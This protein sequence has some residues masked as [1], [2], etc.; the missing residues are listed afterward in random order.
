MKLRSRFL[1][2]GPVWRSDLDAAPEHSEAKG[3]NGLG[4]ALK[5]AKNQV[6]CCILPL[7]N[8]PFGDFV[9]IRDAFT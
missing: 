1:L 4:A 5:S 3:S 6:W 2:A 8:I 9:S 7:K